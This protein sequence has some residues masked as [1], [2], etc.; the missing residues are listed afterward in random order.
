M[1]DN[2]IKEEEGN[3]LSR[4]VRGKSESENEANGSV[5]QQQG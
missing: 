3:E 4:G 1:N 5:L 2:E